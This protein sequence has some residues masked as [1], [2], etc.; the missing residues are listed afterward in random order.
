MGLYMI[1]FVI[2]YL[3]IGVGAGL[4]VLMVLVEDLASPG[5]VTESIVMCIFVLLWPLVSIASGLMII[6]LL[7]QIL[8]RNAWSIKP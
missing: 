4:P 7:V 3:L 6:G 5:T 8:I 1:V 2:I